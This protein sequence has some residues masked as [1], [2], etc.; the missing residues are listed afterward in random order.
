MKLNVSC[1]LVLLVAAKV[2]AADS[3]DYSGPGRLV[4]TQLVTAPFPHASRSAG[5]K[6]KDEIFS[7]AE[8]YADSSVAMFVPTGF[9]EA[10]PVNFV[11]HFHGWRNHVATVLERYRLLEQF[12]AS[13]CNAVLVV[14]QG[15]RDAPDSSGGKLEDADGFRKFMGEV[16]AT[17]HERGILTNRSSE[18]GGVIL[19]AHSGGYQVVSSIL[20]RGGLTEHIKEVWLFDALYAHTETF[21]E[22]QQRARGRLL[23]LYTEHGGTKEETERLMGM[24]RQRQS[25]F[26]QTKEGGVTR[27][28]LRRAKPVFIFTELEHDKVMQGTSA[29]QR[30]L[31]TSVFHA[32]PQ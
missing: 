30:F 1:L 5:H 22:W 28:E 29:F 4:I 23:V 13:G 21:F 2:N 19:S 26:V 7:A 31:E 12:E 20:E 24:Y 8:H 9:H 17:L 15:P 27:E 11:V 32:S 25:D 10:G 16:M 18:I 6:Y 3:V 14:P